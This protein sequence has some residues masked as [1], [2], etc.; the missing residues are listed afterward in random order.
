MVATSG[1]PQPVGEV[2]QRRLGQNLGLE[3][4][5]LK[6]DIELVAEGF[7]QA[8]EAR[9][10]EVGHVSAER[11]V[12]RA[13]RTAGQG[14][15][16]VRAKERVEREVRLVALLRVE[17]EGGDEPHQVPVAGL[18]LGEEHDRRAGDAQ[19]G[20]ARGGGRRRRRNRP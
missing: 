15:Q 2:D 13:V 14:D 12:D 17:P 18:G 10:G 6:F 3:P 9:L 1:R 5:A 4:V 8:P 20:K 19:F 11:P 16:A 7:A